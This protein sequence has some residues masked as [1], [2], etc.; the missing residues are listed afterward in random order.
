MIAF[1]ADS[2]DGPWSQPFTVAPLNTR[3]YN[4]Q[5][6][7]TLRIVGKKKTTYL[8]LGDQVSRLGLVSTGLFFNLKC[9]GILIHYGKADIFGCPW[10]LTIKKGRLNW[11]GMTYMIWMCRFFAVRSVFEEARD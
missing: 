9:S 1:R 7:F 2:L 5:S 11:F 10:R 4:S 3:T 6:G 8:Y